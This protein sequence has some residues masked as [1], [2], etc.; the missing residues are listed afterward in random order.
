[1]C[2]RDV[3]DRGVVV[4]GEVEWRYLT[5]LGSAWVACHSLAPGQAGTCT[6]ASLQ[7]ITLCGGEGVVVMVVRGF[8]R[9]GNCGRHRETEEEKRSIWTISVWEV[10]DRNGGY[11]S[12]RGEFAMSRGVIISTK[13]TRRF[14][15]DELQD[16]S[17]PHAS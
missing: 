11:I 3:W 8:G 4:R 12:Y 1:M 5:P 16:A 6:P 7:L 14:Y 15:R 10:K 2:V 13:Q 9:V 17:D